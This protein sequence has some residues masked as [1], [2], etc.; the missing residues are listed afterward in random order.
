MNYLNLFLCL[1]AFTILFS[2]CKNEVPDS[3]SLTNANEIRGNYIERGSDYLYMKIDSTLRTDSSFFN[4]LSSL[5]ILDSDIKNDV[6]FILSDSLRV[7][8]IS[9]SNYIDTVMRLKRLDKIEAMYFFS[10]EFGIIIDDTLSVRK[11]D[12]TC[13]LT[14]NNY[15][16]ID[17][18]KF[19]KLESLFVQC[20]RC[21]II[22]PKKKLK[23]LSIQT[24]KMDTFYRDTSVVRPI[25]LEK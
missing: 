22:L 17:A 9:Y 13:N 20:D 15:S 18:T 5:T 1:F 3:S 23:R 24:S 21:E 7:L 19:P 6:S 8:E 12:L 10:N 2:S 25:I 14:K 16:Y 11:L 4:P